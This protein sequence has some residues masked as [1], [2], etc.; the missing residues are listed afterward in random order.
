MT[1][2]EITLQLLR[3][4]RARARANRWTQGLTDWLWRALLLCAVLRLWTALVSPGLRVGWPVYVLGVAG[5]A[6][7]TALRLRHGGTLGAAAVHVDEAADLDSEM[8]SGH[9]F[10][11]EG[12]DT[13]WTE[14]HLQRV[15]ATA[16]SLS[17]ER[18]VPREMPKRLGVVAAAALG[19]V[20][21]SFFLPSS[22][23]FERLAG[24]VALP[25]VAGGELADADPLGQLDEAGVGEDA[26][27]P[28]QLREEERVNLPSLL[29]GEQEGIDALPEEGEM[30][31]EEGESPEPEGSVMG[32]ERGSEEGEPQGESQDMEVENP[33]DLPRS[34]EGQETPPDPSASSEQ[35]EGEPAEE[36]GAMM[37]GGDEVFLQEEGEELD[38]GELSEEEIGHATREGGDEQV[39]EEGE[40]STLEVE[41]EREILALPPE[42]TPEEEEEDKIEEITRSERSRL[43]TRNVTARSEFARQ[44]DLHGE[45]IHWRYRA[46]IRDYFMKMRARDNVRRE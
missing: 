16:T 14:L 37:P 20:V 32:D 22:G 19:F 38:P 24:A 36:P 26:E 33:E 8:T 1:P 45:P 6:M 31:P 41:L 18:L 5:L 34:E 39:F 25:D 23:L 43:E 35:S 9:W 28:E 30:A 10:A 40:L 11:T 42:E 4:V 46:L 17:A 29:E 27:D 15:A 13:A 21:A 44:E 12:T 7:H 3:L 2:Q